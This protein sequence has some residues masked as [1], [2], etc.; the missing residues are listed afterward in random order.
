MRILVTG[1]SGLVG[2]ALVPALS[3]AGHTVVR[4][5][6]GSPVPGEVAWDPAA[7]RMD[8]ASLEGTDAVVHLAGENIAGRWTKEKKER[9]RAS[10]VDGTS[11]VARA[12]AATKTRPRVLVAAS[13]VG[14]YGDRG[15]E[16]LDESSAR[17]TGFLPDVCEAWERAS[18][19]A[20]DAGVRVVHLRFGVVL[21]PKGGALAR[22]LTPFKLGVGGVIGSGRQWMPLVSIDD[23]VAA[24]L[25]VLAHGDLAGPVNV[26]TPTQATNRDFTKALGRALGRPTVFPMPA[27]AARLAFG[28]MADGLLL[29]SARV[30]P[31]RLLASGFA[32]RHADAESALRHVLGR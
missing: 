24:A 30:A 16:A 28:E 26:C 27:F 1:A 23:L 7:G 12:I 17:G 3:A 18:D 31:K 32:F 21:S 11:L 9:I 6:R 13:A 19:A 22:M 29:A 5:V 4:A 15:D 8:A 10:R 14:W 2:S 20:R 25:H